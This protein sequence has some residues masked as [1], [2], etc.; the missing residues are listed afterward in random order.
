MARDKKIEV[1]LLILGAGW[2]GLLAALLYSREKKGSV[3]ILEKEALFGGLAQTMDIQGFKADIGGH[4]LFFKK[5][6]NISFLKEIMREDILI[7]RT[8]KARIYIE[9]KYLHYPPNLDFVWKFNKK[10]LLGILFDLFRFRSGKKISNFEDWVKFHYGETL[11]RLVFKE[12][13]QK[14]WGQHCAGLSYSWAENRIGKDGLLN[15]FLNYFFKKSTVKERDKCFYYPQ[16]GIGSLVTALQS[17]LSCDVQMTTGVSLVGFSMDGARL[18]SLRYLSEGNTHEVN[19]KEIISTIPLTEL[20]PAIPDIPSV[21]VEEAKNGIRYRSLIMVYLIIDKPI[22]SDW[23]WCYFPSEK[24]IFSR[25]HEP[26]LWSESLAPE[27]KTLLSVE[28]FCDHMDSRWNMDDALIIGKVKDALKVVGLLSVEDSFVHAQI[29]R[30]KYAYPLLYSGFEVPLSRVKDWLNN[31]INLH[32]AGRNGTSSY[33][34]M[35]DCL[36]DVKKVVRRL[37][38]K[39]AN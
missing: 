8:R 16:L 22:V 38:D 35:E 11:Y 21:I 33:F 30:V 28:I 23:S 17:R 5:K 25:I 20:V 24:F 13:S 19:F 39:G 7:L 3:L 18:S 31:Y 26:K 36:D 1:D 6:E 9:G 32:L 15:F 10:Y 37:I 27:G 12:Y 34:D 14:V 29:M 2:S 4:A